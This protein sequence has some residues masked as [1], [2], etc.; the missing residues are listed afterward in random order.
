VA[1]P[2]SDTSGDEEP[3]AACDVSGPP[4]DS[5]PDEAGEFDVSAPEPTVA[6]DPDVADSDL[7]DSGEA[8]PGATPDPGQS[9]PGEADPGEAD[10]PGVEVGGASDAA[11]AEY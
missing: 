4:V 1:A 7:A 6:A 10:D 3:A 5:G 2:D 8:D 11:G 9:D